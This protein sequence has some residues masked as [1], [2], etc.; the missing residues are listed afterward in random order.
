MKVKIIYRNYKPLHDLYAS[1]RAAPP[2]SVS[3][4]IPSPKK[5][6]QRFYPLY[7][8]FGDNYIARSI[9]SKA[10]EI[11]FDVNVE[12]DVEV[13][14]FAQLVPGY[15][16]AKPYVVDFEHA[17]SLMNF[18]ELDEIVV[19]KVARFLENPFCKAI[20]PFSNAAANSLRRLLE[21]FGNAAT[22]MEK[23]Q[24]I[25]PALPN[26]YVMYKD[27][28][29]YSLVSSAPHKFRLLFVGNSVYKKGLHELLVAFKHLEEKYPN[30]ELYVI[31]DAPEGLKRKYCS[32][33]IKYFIPQFSHAD[34][35]T[36]FYLPCDVF[37]LPTHDDTFGM[38]SLY[39][40][41]CGTPVIATKQ[42]AIPEIVEPGRN[43]LLVQSNRLHLEE[44]A[45]P[46]RA[47]TRRYHSPRFEDKLLVDQLTHQIEY[48]YLNPNVLAEMGQYAGIDFESEGKFSI[49]VR[50]RKL[51]E[52][53][54]LCYGI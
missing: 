21:S 51:E 19:Q 52:V 54:K 22:I 20:L 37:V 3:Y 1:L 33:R 24:V 39:A 38:A 23:V 25:Y 2:R 9:I 8:R 6:L 44:V 27:R 15:L 42:F 30:L 36:K 4:V 13:L 50:N 41:S 47:T 17:A 7:L 16:P 32:N 18:V 10:Q 40:L 49:D 48:L 26:Y 34:I 11:L 46:N 14:H 31:S 29:D 43:G 5:S 28:A 35:I 45:F 12:D 53:Y